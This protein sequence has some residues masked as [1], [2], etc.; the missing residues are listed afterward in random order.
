MPKVLYIN[1]YL[2]T[3][4]LKDIDVVDNHSL[5]QLLNAYKIQ[6][7]IKFDQPNAFLYT[8]INPTQRNRSKGFCFNN[9]YYYSFGVVASIDNTDISINMGSLF[10]FFNNENVEVITESNEE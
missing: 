10:S 6:A 2:E 9:K 8:Q 7:I 3:I 1:P 5:S 4:S